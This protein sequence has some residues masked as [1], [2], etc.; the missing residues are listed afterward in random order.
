MAKK[1]S[2]KVTPKEVVQQL[3]VE[4]TN[5]KLEFEI[6]KNEVSELRSNLAEVN[7][8]LWRKEAHDELAETGQENLIDPLP[9]KTP[10]YKRI[11]G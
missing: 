5:L 7:R 8:A 3:Q 2:V 9:E 11:F 1:K 6:V 4:V 10:W